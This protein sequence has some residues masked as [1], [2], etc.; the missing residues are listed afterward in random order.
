MSRPVIE[1]KSTEKGFIDM[2]TGQREEKT[3]IPVICERE[4]HYREMRGIEQKALAAVLGINKNAISNWENGR[5]RPDVG[6]IPDLCNALGIT[7]YQLFGVEDPSLEYSEGERKL[8]RQYRNLSSGHRYVIE[9]L[10]DSLITVEKAANI[11]ALREL[12]L[13][14]KPLAAG[15]G[16]PTELEE[17]GSP[18]FLYDSPDVRIADY[19]FSI[20]GE[21]MEPEYHDG[22]KVLVEKV[23]EA[24]DMR[25]G[26]VGA[27]MINNEMY[28]KVYEADGLHSLN[29]AFAPMRFEDEESVYLIGKVIGKVDHEPT[30]EEI[31]QFTAMRE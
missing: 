30:A 22:D 14:D 3:A 18:I 27:F 4:K 12:I 31:T 28:I 13:F 6:L 9:K 19:V 25:Y 20:N 10:A 23:P 8:I 5:A 16:D 2:K 17:E 24:D 21:S 15:V 7:L 26:E 29:K 11:P 1:R